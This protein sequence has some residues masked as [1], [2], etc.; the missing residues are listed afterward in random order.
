MK[1]GLAE[2]NIPAWRIWPAWLK[3]LVR[4]LGEKSLG[5]A[6]IAGLLLVLVAYQSP[7]AILVDIGGPVD[8]LH[9][10]GFHQPETSGDANFRWSMGKSALVFQGIGKPISSFPVTLQFSSGR[11]AGAANLPVQL[12]VNG[13]ALPPLELGPTSAAYVVTIDPAWI[14]LSGD[15]R[16]DFQTDTFKSGTDKRDLGFLADFARADLPVGATLPSLPVL[17]WLIVCGFLLYW[18]IRSFW[19]VPRVAGWI[20]LGFFAVASGG[21]AVQRLLVTVYA[22]RLA[23]TLILAILVATLAEWLSRY[24]TRLAGWRDDHAVPEWAWAGLRAL[25]ALSVL[26]KVGGLLYPHT[27]IIDAEF[28]LKYVT[29]MYE[30]RDFD[31]YFGKSLALSVMPPDEWG[32][33]RAFIPYS[34]FFYVVASPLAYLP[35]PLLISVS[36][37]SGIFESLKVALVFLAALALGTARR[38]DSPRGSS[39]IALAAAG[40]YAAI[41]ATFLLQQFGNWPTLTSLWLLT[42]WAAIT[43]MFWPRITKPLIWLIST[44]ALTLTM[45]SYTVTAVYVGVFVGLLVVLGWLFAPAE[46]KR[47][48]ALLFSAVGA[49]VL[50]LLIYYGQYVDDI[51]NET[52]PTF[53]NAVNEQGSL[54]TLRPSWWA[55]ISGPMAHAFES[56]RLDI[57]YGIGL[58]GALWV[59]LRRGR[60]VEESAEAKSRQARQVYALVSRLPGMGLSTASWQAVWIGAWLLLFPF[61]T[62]ADFYVDQAFK[63]YWVALPVVALVAAVWL[64]AARVRGRGTRALM[65][66]V[67]LLPVVLVWQSLSLWVFRLFFH[68]R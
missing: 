2:P 45:L 9:A 48:A 21:L 54:S 38:G 51:I 20:T 29:Y 7:R 8:N 1:F 58:A 60:K 37:A 63:E 17:L 4:V 59:F 53:G 50:S 15:L 23:Y 36:V 68:N 67:W 31:T 61:F 27:F 12:A 16:I 42:L 55:F 22:D 65:T 10:V 18:M 32:S 62:F 39:R 33:A 26:L 57:I 19:V 11:G 13:H 44:L 28:H 25:V 40:I 64:L 43:C 24:V 34:P 56:Y 3:L 52:L 14:D 46:R 30:G 35:F 5:I 47:W 49:S 41:P 6:L 66:L